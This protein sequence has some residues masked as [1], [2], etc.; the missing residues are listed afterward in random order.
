ML[1]C[2]VGSALPGLTLPSAGAY[3]GVK[4]SVDCFAYIRRGGT[5]PKL[6]RRSLRWLPQA[7]RPKRLHL[8]F[9]P[10]WRK[11]VWNSIWQST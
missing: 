11:E 1:S 7:L 6:Q 3:W 9:N 5:L 2:T 10:P 8:T 4:P